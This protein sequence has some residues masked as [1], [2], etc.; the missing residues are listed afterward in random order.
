MPRVQDGCDVAMWKSRRVRIDTPRTVNKEVTNAVEFHN[1]SSVGS[2]MLP[3]Q[4]VVSKR[5]G[6][7]RDDD[8]AG[9]NAEL[10]WCVW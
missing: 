6:S 2:C 1:I 3:Y 9:V 7:K 10:I 4:W 5:A 8:G